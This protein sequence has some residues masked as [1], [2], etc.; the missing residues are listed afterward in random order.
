MSPQEIRLRRLSG[1]HL[2][3][4][5]LTNAAGVVTS[6]AAIQAQEYAMAKWALALRMKGNATDAE[7]EADFNEGRIL[8]THTMRPTWHFIANEDIRWML[9][10]TAPR[11]MA[12]N[13]FMYKK[14]GLDEKI[15]SESFAI[16]EKVLEG[17]NY[18]TREEIK[19]I[20]DGKGLGGDGMHMAHIMME[21]E[22]EGIVCSGPRIGN[23]FTY[24]LIDER[25]P[26]ARKLSR[27]EGL[28]ELSQR[29]FTTRGP[30]SVQDFTNWSGLTVKDAREAMAMIERDLDRFTYDGIDYYF[31][32][33]K[34]ASRK[35]MNFLMPDYDEYGMSYK[36]R[37]VLLN[38]E[39][40][41]NKRQ[42]DRVVIVDG[43]IAGTWRRT[44]K[45]DM[46]QI[47]LQL[48][49]PHKITDKAV[50]GLLGDYAK[51]LGKKIEVI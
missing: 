1:Q 4:P 19:T 30:A 29:Y 36:D 25:A 39:S 35:K 23:H 6:M 28:K 49:P 37:S 13:K 17:S 3:T 22:L 44:L 21:A 41:G 51:F 5:H 33:E 48:F 8:R 34:P 46:V 10:I 27:E 50:E 40:G 42:F 31:T 38:P 12:V 43:M 45:K 16:I 18:L 20:L 26:K 24:A 2:L 9:D 14:L 7:I 11:V 32:G 15:F 47:E